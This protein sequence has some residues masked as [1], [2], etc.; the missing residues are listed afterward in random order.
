MKG[1]PLA[2]LELGIEKSTDIDLGERKPKYYTDVNP[3]GTV[4][5]VSTIGITV[6]EAVIIAEF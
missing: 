3:F 5:Y 6:A 2:A 1:I 4:P